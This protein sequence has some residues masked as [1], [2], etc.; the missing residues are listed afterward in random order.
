MCETIYRGYNFDNDILSKSE[1]IFDAYDEELINNIKSELKNWI[2]LLQVDSDPRL[3]INWSVNGGRIFY[4]IRK[5]DH[6]KGDFSSAWC[7]Q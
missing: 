3:N 1:E 7:V 2:L 5:Q 6:E 4:C